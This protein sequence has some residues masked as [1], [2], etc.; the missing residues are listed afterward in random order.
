MEQYLFQHVTLTFVMSAFT[1]VSALAW[2][3]ALQAVFDTYFP[4]PKSNALYKIVY[5]FAITVLAIG[6]VYILSSRFQMKPDGEHITDDE[7]ENMK[8]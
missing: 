6:L 3:S 4:S 8:F 2:N 7:I 1:L 5:A